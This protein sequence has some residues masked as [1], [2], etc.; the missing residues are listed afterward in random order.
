MLEGDQVRGDLGGRGLLWQREL[1]DVVEPLVRQLRD[2]RRRR[3]PGRGV[4]SRL[5]PA[6]ASLHQHVG[7]ARAEGLLGAAPRLALL[8]RVPEGLQALVTN[9]GEASAPNWHQQLERL[10]RDP[11][12]QPYQYANPGQHGSFDVFSYG[13]DRQEGGEGINGDIGNWDL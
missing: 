7:V 1:D 5:L 12:D 8:Q 10:P 2:L 6:G 4:E 13:A 11:W 9:P 3:A